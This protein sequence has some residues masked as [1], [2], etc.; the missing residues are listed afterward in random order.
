MAYRFT[1]ALIFLLLLSGQSYSKASR[2]PVFQS[3]GMSIHSELVTEGLQ[4]PWGFDFIGS[5]EMLVTERK[6]KL[7]RLNLETRKRVSISGLPKF[8]VKSQGGLLDVIV[9]PQFSK[10]NLIYFTYATPYKSENSVRL[11]QA[12][13]KGNRLSNVKTLFTA[14]AS[15]D[16]NIHFGSRLVF[17]KA[18]YLYMSIGDRGE[19]DR[20]Q[21]LSSHGGKIIRLKAD[22]TVPKDNPFVGR[23]GARPEIWTLGHRNPQGLAIHPKT[24]R[25]WEQEHG[26]RGGDE[27]NLLKKGG[28]Y[29]WPK[30]TYGKEYWGPSIGRKKGRGT[31]QPLHQFTPSIAPSGLTIYMG[32]AFPKW[33]G[34]VFSGAMK[35]T[36]INRQVYKK[37]KVIKE[38]RLLDSW[39]QRIRNIKTGPDG[40]IYFSTDAGE[41]FRLVPRKK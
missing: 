1:A 35:L 10:N 19:R 27:I 41:I 26:P 29:G 34:N 14:E 18:G 7:H 33:N 8:Y 15:S 21:D 3:E 12:V 30:V 20:A 24:G 39:G 4:I 22:G 31:I 5:E 6:G 25:I 40:F 16:N 23:K 9:H 11:S 17:D 32:K 36:H 28:N 38:E 37:G 2:V 13:L